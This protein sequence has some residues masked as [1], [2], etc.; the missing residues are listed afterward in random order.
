MRKKMVA[1]N[2]KMNLNS[3][4]AVELTK[5]VINST[6]DGGAEVLLCPSFTLINIVSNL[7]NDSLVKIGAQNLYWEQKGAF[8][9][10]VSAY[11]IADAGCSH[12][13]IGHSERRQYFGETD[14]SVQ[15]KTAAALNSGL[16]PLVCVGETIKEREEGQTEA[17]IERQTNDAL[18]RFE[19]EDI[20]NIIIAYEPI[21][22]IGTGHTATPASAQ[23]VHSQI[24]NWLRDKFG[25]EI[26]SSI[27]ILYGGSVKSDNAATLFS[28]EDIDGGLVGGASLN[29]ED[30]AK[31]IEAAR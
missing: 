8:T 15:R 16:I 26:A 27:R 20:S 4:E 3:V 12:V 1:G 21:W 11:M 24:R 6:I 7:I 23:E 19:D 14:H 30:F 29:G 2:W 5:T 9:G 31:I 13:I 25:D 17:V 10:E 18:G 22:A 28:E